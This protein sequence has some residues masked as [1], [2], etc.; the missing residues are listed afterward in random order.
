MTAVRAIWY[1]RLAAPQS[2]SAVL[3]WRGNRAIGGDKA[4]SQRTLRL[5]NFH[6]EWICFTLKVKSHLV[7]PLLFGRISN[8]NSNGEAQPETPFEGKHR[9]ALLFP[10]LPRWFSCPLLVYAEGEPSEMITNIFC[11][12]SGHL[13]YRTVLWE[14]ISLSTYYHDDFNQE[15]VGAFHTTVD[16]GTLLDINLYGPAYNTQTYNISNEQSTA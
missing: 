5:F 8:V 12:V 14:V 2:L 15:S 16:N 9:L 10:P 13:T 11:F 7:N 4:V 6:P 1:A 3:K